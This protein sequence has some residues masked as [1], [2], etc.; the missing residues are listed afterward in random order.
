MRDALFQSMASMRPTWSHVRGGMEL[1]S[2]KKGLQKIP[3]Q[4]PEIHFTYT[5]L[6][7]DFDHTGH[8][9]RSWGVQKR[10]S[11]LLPQQKLPCQS[12]REDRTRDTWGTAFRLNL[13]V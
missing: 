6:Q 4:G 12:P 1:E 10:L 7:S 3:T 5:F 9:F 11:E 13:I 2:S 8:Y